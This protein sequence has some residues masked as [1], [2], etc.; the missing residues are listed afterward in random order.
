MHSVNLA[1][2]PWIVQQTY[3]FAEPKAAAF[4]RELAF[5]DLECTP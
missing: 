3:Y 5:Y 1:S 4:N 2:L